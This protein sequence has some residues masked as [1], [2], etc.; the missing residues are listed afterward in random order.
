MLK[1]NEVFG[2]TIQGEGKS[3][4]K[5]VLFVR[6]SICNL[7]CV[8]CDT[9][10]TWNWTGTSFKH[11]VKF[12]KE[13]EIHEFTAQQVFD[14]LLHLGL[15]AVRA[16]VI[17]GGEPMIQQKA[18]LPLIRLLKDYGCHVE[19]ETNGTIEPSLELLQEVDQFNCSPKVSNSGNDTHLREKA[20]ALR[21]LAAS[22][23]T[24]FKFVVSRQEDITEILDLVTRYK[25]NP[26][27]LMPEGRTKEE[28]AAHT[29]FV[30]EL[31][32]THGFLFTPRLHILK[33]GTQRAV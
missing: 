32:A 26:V 23:K 29:D 31:C 13:K 33:F 21:T 19:M 6:T 10:Y 28:L 3:L 16:V 27:Y 18:L 9:P 15:L 5:P 11:P 7:H 4:N 17:S 30:T 2:P 24:N 20:Q 25:L 1:I 22:P 8:W 12:D 14:K